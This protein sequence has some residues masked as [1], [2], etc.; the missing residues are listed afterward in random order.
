M[1]SQFLNHGCKGLR[2]DAVLDERYAEGELGT[3]EVGVLRIGF[4]QLHVP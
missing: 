2:I 3:V 1:L 4:G